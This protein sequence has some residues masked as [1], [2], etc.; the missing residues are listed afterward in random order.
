MIIH[1]LLLLSPPGLD[2]DPIIQFVVSS[3]ISGLFSLKFLDFVDIMLQT[4]NILLGS[5]HLGLELQSALGNDL[6]VF[7]LHFQDVVRVFVQLRLDLFV[8]LRYRPPQPLDRV[9]PDVQTVRELF[10]GLL[11]TPLDLSESSESRS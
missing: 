6:L 11:E 8:N 2:L 7:D 4:S 9:L 1:V 10:L 5:R 3:I